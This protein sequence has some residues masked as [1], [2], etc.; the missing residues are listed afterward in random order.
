[1]SDVIPAIAHFTAAGKKLKFFFAGDV[2]QR[3]FALIQVTGRG[4]YPRSSTT[5]NT[6]GRRD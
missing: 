6:E 4:L 2:F 3:E 5:E 1:M